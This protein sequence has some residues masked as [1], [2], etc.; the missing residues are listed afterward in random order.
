MKLEWISQINKT[1][2]MIKRNPTRRLSFTLATGKNNWFEHL[3]KSFYSRL[4]AI[5]GATGSKAHPRVMV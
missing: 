4:D 5:L 3:Y 1:T 2:G